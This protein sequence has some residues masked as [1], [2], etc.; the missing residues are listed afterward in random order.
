ME[1]RKTKR[2]RKERDTLLAERLPILR[3]IYKTCVETYPINSIIPNASDVFLNPIVQSL[4]IHP[5]TIKDKDLETLGTFF[6][7]IVLYWRTITEK[8]LL[9]MISPGQDISASSLLELATTIFSCRFC[10]NE[11]LTY[12]QV[13]IHRCASHSQGTPT[14]DEDLPVLRR[15][16]DCSYWNSNNFLAFDAPKIASLSEAI[17]LCGLDPKS[18]TREDM[19]KLDPIFECLSCNDVR[20]GRCTLPW[21]GVVCIF[22]FYYYHLIA[23]GW[24]MIGFLILDK[25]DFIH[26]LILLSV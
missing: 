9:N 7:N 2:L 21:L 19:D 4:L 5:P 18:A 26:L 3:K 13:L 12:P 17:K 10:H 16:L 14:T 11:A 8:K 24:I 15:F 1:N 6:P 20:K 25:Y 22:I 23:I